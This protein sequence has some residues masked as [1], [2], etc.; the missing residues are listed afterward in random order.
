MVVLELGRVSL[1]ASTA[2]AG[3]ED[4]HA[5][6][7]MTPAVVALPIDGW[8]EGYDV[9]LLDATGHALSHQL[10]HHVNLIMP[11]KR[12][13]F[14]PIMLRIG[15][16]GA[17]TPPIQ[18]PPV[19]GYR[20]HAGDTLL[21]TAMLHNPT[22]E[23]QPNMR[24]RVRLAYRPID[25]WFHP[26]SIYP[27]YL[28]VMP[29][30]GQKAYDLPAGHSEKH[31]EARPAVDGRILAL[32]AHLHKYAKALRLDDVT[33]GRTIWN[34]APIT[35][36]TGAIVDMPLKKFWWRLGLPIHAN[37]VYR[38]TAV[39]DNPTGQMIPDGAM[40]ALGGVIVP[41]DAA[42][43]PAI[44][45]TDSTYQ[46]DARVTYETDDHGM[47]GMD[48]QTQAPPELRPAPPNGMLTTSTV[49]SGRPPQTR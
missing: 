9:E 15:A 40:G 20:V 4:H 27:L 32:G 3:Q 21:V 44:D 36:S 37:H 19:L 41:D 11:E 31:W 5:M 29:P 33:A 28:D 38:V 49:R 47:P 13:L 35:D 17:E 2:P 39:Y 7:E 48:M 30:A 16:L 25:T 18:L 1:A 22:R 6:V 23:A 8:I 46:L 45:R 14:S 42:Q 43:W 26:M 24:V 12:E 34:T 10:I